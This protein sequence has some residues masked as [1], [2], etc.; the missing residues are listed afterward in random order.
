MSRSKL[1][2]ANAQ[3]MFR[4][5]NPVRLVGAPN[6]PLRDGH[7]GQITW[8]R[9]TELADLTAI[10]EVGEAFSTPILIVNTHF[11]TTPT[12]SIHVPCTHLVS[13]NQPPLQDPSIPADAIQLIGGETDFTQHA[14]HSHH[15][16]VDTTVIP[17]FRALV[18]NAPT[19]GPVDGS[20]P[21]LDVGAMVTVAELIE[22]LESVGAGSE[23]AEGSVGA[24][25]L[26]QLGR[27]GSPQSRNAAAMRSHVMAQVC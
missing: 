26:S 24:A 27:F 2:S 12:P 23:A 20:K 21:L 13:R 6:S 14:R 19:T 3:L 4:E 7:T 10:F 15:F 17:E 16:F 1:N 25:L 8:L 9:P 18:L 5:V 11:L 22:A